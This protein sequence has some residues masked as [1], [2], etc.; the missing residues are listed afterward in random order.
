MKISAPSWLRVSAGNLVQSA[1][2]ARVLQ[3]ETSTFSAVHSGEECS[4]GP[5][6]SES[7]EHVVDEG[8]LQA[9]PIG[10]DP[11][12]GTV[13]SALA[14]IQGFQQFRSG[15]L[16]PG[17]HRRPPSCREYPATAAS[18]AALPARTPRRCRSGTR[19]MPQRWGG[20]LDAPP[21]RR[22][23][24]REGRPAAPGNT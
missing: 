17:T 4:A 21:W 14:T 1:L 12:A 16:L 13:F 6:G 3:S 24:C 9:V 23:R 19:R 11:G 2:P 8:L 22:V 20:Q 5:E 7:G 15:S 18:T 10:V